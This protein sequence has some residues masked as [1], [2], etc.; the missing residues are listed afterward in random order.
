MADAQKRKEQQKKL[1]EAKK[2]ASQKGPMSKF[3]FYPFVSLML[4]LISNLL[5]AAGLGKKK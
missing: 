1:E 5:I 2:I 4:C 3:F